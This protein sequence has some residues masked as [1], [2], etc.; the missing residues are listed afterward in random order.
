MTT[1]LR[2]SIR[3]HG[4]ETRLTPW[5]HCVD[6]PWHPGLR[7]GGYVAYRIWVQFDGLRWYQRHEWKCADGS[8]EFDPWIKGAQEWGRATSAMEDV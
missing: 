7:H 3:L 2:P 4:A 6:G 5:E 1:D 8:T